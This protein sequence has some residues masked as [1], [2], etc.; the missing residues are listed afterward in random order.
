[1]GLSD[2]GNCIIETSDN[3]FIIGGSTIIPSSDATWILKLDECGDTI[4]GKQYLLAPGSGGEDVR[5]VVENSNGSFTFWGDQRDTIEAATS[6]FLLKV[7][8]NGDSL[9]HVIVNAGYNDWGTGG[10][11]A[12]NDGGFIGAGYY[13]VSSKVATAFT[14]K[15]N[16]LGAIEWVQTYGDSTVYFRTLNI[17]KTIDGGY[18]LSGWAQTID[19]PSVTGDLFLLKT[20]SLGNKQWSRTYGSPNHLEYQGYGIALNE[21]GYLIAGNRRIIPSVYYR[22]YAVKTDSTGNIEW[23]KFYSDSL[24]SVTLTNAVQ[25]RDNNY[26][27]VGILSDTIGN[28]NDVKAYYLKID[29]YGNKI[30]DRKY[31]Y[32]GGITHNYINDVKEL[33]NGDIVSTGYMIPVGTTLTTRNDV[34]VLKT[35]SCGYTVGDT[36]A[37]AFTIVI[38]NNEVAVTI[39]SN[40]VCRAVWHW[41][42]GDTTNNRNPEPYTYPDTG[43]YTIMLIT[44]AGNTIDTAYQT[45]TI[46]TL[47]IE[48]VLKINEQIK[49]YPNPA[50]DE[51]RI[52]VQGSKLKVQSVRVYDVAGRMV[53]GQQTTDYSKNEQNIILNI[54]HVTQGLYFLQIEMSNG[55]RVVRKVV[56]E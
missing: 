53:H 48:Y 23:E 41:G 15:T 19:A 56:K 35:D 25:L 24:I 54:N 2:F 34:L 9:S 51:I 17:N 8:N 13:N 27:L 31:T 12:Q 16:S 22:G 52:E 11:I 33:A 38:D 1:V 18:I 55:E 39:Q 46:A 47:G 50:T 14:V 42:T 30:W 43:T 49:V 29:K 26:L 5:R 20:D 44:Y 6:C 7:S 21:G 40:T 37:A 45:V 4:W 3:K 32:Y 36:T 28:S 10:V